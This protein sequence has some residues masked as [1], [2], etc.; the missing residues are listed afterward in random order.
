MVGLFIR[1]RAWLQAIACWLLVLAASPCTAPFAT[2]DL[3]PSAPATTFDT[4][5]T[6]ISND[7]LLTV[8]G[9]ALIHQTIAKSA[10][11][12]LD[13]IVVRQTLDSQHAVL[14]L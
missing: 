5:K 7:D 9:P 1:H 4:G 3:L 13:A 8:P 10:T 6:K 14:R 12:V 2:F 11:P